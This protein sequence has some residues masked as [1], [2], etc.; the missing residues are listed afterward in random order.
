MALMKK[1]ELKLFLDKLFEVY[2]N[3]RCELNYIN[4]F[5][6][7]VAIIL[8]AQST[9]KGVNKVTE[10]LFPVAST[11]EEMIL[12]GEER[13]KQYIR[14]INYFNNKA[15]SIIK[16]AHQLIENFNGQIP[17]DF[18]TLKTLSGVGQKTASVFL[19]VAY[20]APF[21]GVDTHVFR[22]CH[23]LNICKGKDPS[24]VQEKLQKIIPASYQP[25][26]ALALVFHGRYVCTAK[27][28]KCAT[29]PLKDVCTAI[30][31]KEI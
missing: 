29:C 16:L 20:H 30:E 31:N 5:T 13:L 22:L 18:E 19:N 27:R 17:T 4:H 8:S 2:P 23:R 21:I 1:N 7:L 24:A 26:V 14:S 25:D 11:P 12:L 15:K 6:L 10:K 3:P 28:P 9:D